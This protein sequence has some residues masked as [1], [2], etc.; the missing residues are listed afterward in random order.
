M[1]QNSKFNLDGK[2]KGEKVMTI[3]EWQVITIR[4]FIYEFIRRD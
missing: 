3:M 4:I 1:T 2:L